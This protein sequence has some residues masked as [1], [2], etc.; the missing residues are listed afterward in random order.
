MSAWMKSLH[1]FHLPVP[2]PIS[3]LSHAYIA[4]PLRGAAMVGPG[5]EANGRWH[6]VLYRARFVAIM[7]G[8]REIVGG[9]GGGKMRLLL[10]AVGV[11]GS[12]MV[13]NGGELAPASGMVRPAATVDPL[14][15]SDGERGGKSEGFTGGANL[16]HTAVSLGISFIVAMV[17]GSLLRVALKTMVTTLVTGGIILWIL[18]TQ[19]IIEPFWND[20]YG[21]VSESRNW[22][23]ARA[24]MVGTL[25]REHLP[26]AGAALVGFGFGLRK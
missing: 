13:W 9:F 25:L 4:A 22:L 15:V 26:S 8:L 2:L 20:Y 23:I 14:R 24:S 5:F 18:Q 19:G 16:G 7:L 17:V 12:G 1:G 11:A 10:A 6:K 21:T 3:I